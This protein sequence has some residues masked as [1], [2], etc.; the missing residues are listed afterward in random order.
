MNLSYKNL[1]DYLESKGGIT[2][3]PNAN[4]LNDLKNLYNNMNEVRGEAPPGN[5]PGHNQGTTCPSFI[6]KLYPGPDL[7]FGDIYHYAKDLPQEVCGQHIDETCHCVNR[8]SAEICQCDTRTDS[9]DCHNRTLQEACECVQRTDTCNCHDRTKID[10]CTCDSR[11]DTCTCVSRDGDSPCLC[12]HRT[13]PTCLARTGEEQCTCKGRSPSCVCRSR[14]ACN[15]N[16]DT[17]T[18]ECNI[19]KICDCHTRTAGCSCQSRTSAET[20]TCQGRTTSTSSSSY[21]WLQGFGLKTGGEYGYWIRLRT[22]VTTRPRQQNHAVRMRMSI[23]RKNLNWDI[24]KRVEETHTIN[25]GSAKR[26]FKLNPSMPLGTGSLEYHWADETFYVTSTG[27]INVGCIAAMNFR[28]RGSLDVKDVVISKSITLPSIP[29]DCNCNNRTSANT[30]RCNADGN[31]CSC[32]TRE[33]PTCPTR[34]GSCGT[35]LNTCTCN[36]Q[37]QCTC[38]TRTVQSNCECNLR[39]GCDCESREDQEVCTCNARTGP[40]DCHNRHGHDECECNARETPLCPNRTSAEPCYCNAR[41]TPQ[42]PSRTSE[43]K[44]PCDGRCACNFEKRFE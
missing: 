42:C 33:T 34:I 16:S 38:E 11:D 25:V 18:C 36:V 32:N 21:E 13:T 6:K 23:V 4:H 28:H 12:D 30:C 10:E 3:T 43:P 39:Y 40:C 5:N 1:K 41:E 35:V 17:P 31:P 20:C 15:C 27:S 29:A 9:C 26:T 14:T 19:K 44:C 37:E 7:S 22:T 8:T 2:I 24:N